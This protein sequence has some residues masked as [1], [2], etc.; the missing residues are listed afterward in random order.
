MGRISPYGDVRQR[1]FETLYFV[2][3]VVLGSASDI[4]EACT[5]VRLL[6]ATVRYHLLHRDNAW[7]S[8]NVGTTKF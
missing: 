2:R 7:K 5:R 6:H 4:K 3:V 8:E 1:L